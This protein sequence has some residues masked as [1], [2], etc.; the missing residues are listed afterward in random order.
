MMSEEPPCNHS[1]T[2][3]HEWHSVC[4]EKGAEYLECDFCRARKDFIEVDVSTDPSIESLSQKMF[5]EAL[6]D[7]F[8]LAIAPSV[9]EALSLKG[10][11][12][13]D[14]AP[15][16]VIGGTIYAIADAIIEARRKKA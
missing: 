8:A 1:T 11:G 15:A 6:R 2:G 12:Q 3:K 14:W 10:Y 7:N 13:K 5:E 16:K 4:S 9:V